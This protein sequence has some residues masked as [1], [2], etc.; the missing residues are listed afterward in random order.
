M[1]GSPSAAGTLSRATTSTSGTV[2][3]TAARST[4]PDDGSSSR[5]ARASS[6]SISRSRRIVSSTTAR[7]AASRSAP[8]P[9]P[10]ADSASSAP[11]L[12]PAI[13]GAQLVGDLAGEAL[14]VAARRRDPRQQAVQR[15]R[16]AGEFVPRRAE[17]EALVEVV[18]APVLGALGHLRDRAQR[19][20]QRVRR[21]EP[22]ADQHEQ[23]EHDRAEHDLVLH[24][25]ERG[26]RIADDHRAH[27]APGP[28]VDDG[29]GEQPHVLGR[30][31]LG[32]PAQAAE[33]LG[34]PVQR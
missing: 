10:P 27:G 20:V 22:A 26:H 6:A 16:Q 31:A 12:S 5:R 18:R 14:L 11:A 1:S 23:G 17:A 15:R 33:R 29:R 24:V 19:A 28:G 7:S 32:G 3:A 13:R 30:V 9:G 21:G 4:D 25:L 8:A 34:G 2:A